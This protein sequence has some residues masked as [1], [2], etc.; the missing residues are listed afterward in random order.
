M[1]MMTTMMH[2]VVC[3]VFFCAKHRYMLR[4]YIDA[5]LNK[6]HAQV[7]AFL[8]FSAS[9][10]YTLQNCAMQVHDDDPFSLPIQ[11][12]HIRHCRVPSCPQVHDQD[13]KSSDD[14]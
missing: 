4:D 14:A 2:D 7:I 9:K 5:T 3:A 6:S 1:L 10:L 12:L 11:T 13:E 8:T